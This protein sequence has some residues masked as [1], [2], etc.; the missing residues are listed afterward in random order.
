MALIDPICMPFV[1]QTGPF[2]AMIDPESGQKILQNR[3]FCS[4]SAGQ[5]QK[6]ALNAL[7]SMVF[8]SHAMGGTTLGQAMQRDSPP[9]DRQR[10]DP[11]SF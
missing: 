5:A 11:F 2:P 8:L 9:P 1:L 4:K 10:N 3:K 7:F 6:R